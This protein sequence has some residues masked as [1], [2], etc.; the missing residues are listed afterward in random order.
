MSNLGAGTTAVSPNSETSSPDRR[1]LR[2]NVI[3]GFLSLWDF[4]PCLHS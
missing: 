1:K 3:L 2:K 4:F